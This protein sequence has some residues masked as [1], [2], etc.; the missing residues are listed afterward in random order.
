MHD[1]GGPG[2]PA[3]RDPRFRPMTLT[4]SVIDAER[5]LK[6][7][8]AARLQRSPA[9]APIERVDRGAR[10]PLSF[11][12]QRLWFLERMGDLGSTYHIPTRLRLGS[13]LDRAALRR[14]LDAIVARHEALRTAFPAS[15]G[16]P[17]QRIAPVEE[18][19]FHLVEH[20]LGG[21]PEAQ[22]KLRRL[23]GEEAR[24]PFDL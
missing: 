24:T 15:D 8:R 10:L 13:E 21:D 1:S 20:D 5:L 9:L 17:A 12:Q 16:V 18:S 6:L 23:L 3:H 4:P 22:P 19:R 2:R 11:A 7:A 14:A